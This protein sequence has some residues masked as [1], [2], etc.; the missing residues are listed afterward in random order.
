MWK[1]NVL[2]GIINVLG[3]NG[4]IWYIFDSN[5]FCYLYIEQSIFKYIL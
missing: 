2:N 4:Y 3:E 5:C 1:V